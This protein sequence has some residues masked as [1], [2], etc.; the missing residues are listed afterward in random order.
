MAGTIKGITVE[1]GGDTTKLG[2]A[3]EDVNKKSKSLSSEL[4]QIN[5]LLKMDPGNADLLA[6]K[7]KVLADAVSNTREKLDTLKNAEKQVQEQFQK[8]EVSEEQVRSLQRE[9]IATTNKLDAYERAVKETADELD[10]LGQNAGGIKDDLNDTKKESDKASD[11]LDDL[12]KSADKAGNSA[13]GLGSK[14]GSAV[15]GGIKAL[16]TAVVALGSALVGSAE[17]SR[18]YR[19]DMGKLSTAFDTAGHS[20]ESAT[21]TYQALQG[22][23]G[24]SDQAV[25]ASNHLAKLCKNEKELATWTDIA[26]GVYAEFGDSLPIENLTE[27]SN[28]TAKTGA[29]TGGL[30]DALNWA[31]VSEDEFQ[32]KLDACTSEQERQALITE[33][34]NGLY[35]ESAEKYRE[36]NAEVIRANEANEALNSTIAEVG[37]SIEPLLTDIKLMGASLLSDLLPGISSVT[38]AFRGMMNGDEGASENLGSALSNLIS[39][40][41]NKIIEILPAVAEVAISLITTLTTTLIQSIPQLI[42]TGIEIILALINGIT[43]AI[44]QITN[45]IVT[46]IPQLVSALVSGIPLM[47]QG[48]VNLLLAIVDAIPQIIPPLISALP[49]IVVSLIDGLLNA[50]PQLLEGA[51]QLLLAIVQA[52]P[53]LNETLTPLIPDIVTNIVTTLIDSLPLLLEGAVELFGAL[54]EAFITV[55]TEMMEIAPQLVSKLAD[56]LKK[57]PGKL[58][59]AIIGAVDKIGVWGKRLISRADEHVKTMV[60]NVFS[61]AGNIPNKISEA[62]SGAID[63]VVTWGTNMVSKAKSAMSNV[64]TAIKNGL[65]TV[66]ST[67]LTIGKNIVQGL[68]NGIKNATTWIK[69]KVKTFAKS[70]LDGMKDALGIHSPSRLF[71]DEVGKQIPAGVAQGVENNTD[72]ANQAVEDMS[73][74][75]LD[76]ELALN[77][78]TINRKLKATFQANTSSNTL[79]APQLMS[80]LQNIHDKLGSLQVVLDSGELVGGIIDPI[81]SALNDKYDRTVRGW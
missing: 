54:L 12:S 13:D 75:L 72:I 74:D 50:I 76:Q 2:K 78:A 69:S 61:V 3:L 57:L 22:I 26:T 42:T 30:A 32:A 19:A 44:P 18:E 66:P 63:K 73:E 28:E 45:A 51:I 4:G 39:D 1:I 24:E 56:A 37:A 31:G 10:K 33:T 20:A 8:G 80:M 64:A 17:S 25:E 23:L 9:I 58:W 77:D 81:D 6:Q 27:A 46:M 60:S 29:I 68:W 49:A 16:G 14:L 5:K 38:E 70:I 15:K 7:Q 11:A 43:T 55:Q 52:I 65:T 67:M 79:N 34:L 71:A 48:A 41:L 47:I 36:A 62:I 21:E 40:L 35:S 53:V 59:D